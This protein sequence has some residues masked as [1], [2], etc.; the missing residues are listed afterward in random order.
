MI[1]DITHLVNSIRLSNHIV[2]FT[3]AGIST[4]SGIPDFRSSNGLYTSGPY[5]G[6]SPE[7]ILSQEFFREV[8]N[9][10]IFYQFY[11]ERIMRMCEKEPNR[12]HFALKKLEDMGKVKAIVTQ[13]I[14][15]LHNKAG[16]KKVIELHGNCT[17][18]RCV[19]ACGYPCEY[20]EFVQLVET[21]GI[22]KCPNCDGIIRPCTVLFDEALPDDAYDEAFNL[23]RA[24]ELLIVVGSSLLVR[25]ACD[26][27][28]EVRGTG[29]M[30]ILN[31]SDT[32]YDKYADI[33]I[34]EPCGK[35]LEEAIKALDIPPV[36]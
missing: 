35:V 2:V 15:N 24:T 33:I 28:R 7:E 8:I 19:S 17:K 27:V 5:K 14:D 32:P 20:P 31:T 25:P 34:H 18:F 23:I 13:N 1:A 9:R 29:M 10:P 22:A 21:H 6:Y 11:K 12:A 26:L 4:E 30:A 36:V 16:S 3:G